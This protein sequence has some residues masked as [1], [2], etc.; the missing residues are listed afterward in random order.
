MKDFSVIEN[1]PE[2]DIVVE[3]IGGATI[4]LDFTTRALKAGKSV[5]TSN[6]EL[7]ATHGYELLQLAR[8]HGVQ[9]SLRGQRGRRHPHPP[10]P[11]LLPGRQRAERGLRHSQRHHQLYPHPD[12]PRGPDL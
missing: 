10:A 5:V 1:D 8:E 12:D 6:K 11:D 3:T 9:L 2:V 4:A 7:V